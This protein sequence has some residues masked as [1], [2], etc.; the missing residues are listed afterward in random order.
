MKANIETNE[1]VESM[2]QY[3]SVWKLLVGELPNSDLK[4]RPGLSIS[5]PIIRFLSG[6]RY[7]LL[8]H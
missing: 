8:S 5:W 3:V 6:V 4:D 1:V 2:E 7:F